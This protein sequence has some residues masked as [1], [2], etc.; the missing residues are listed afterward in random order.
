MSRAGSGMGVRGGALVVACV[1]ACLWLCGRVGGVRLRVCRVCKQSY[2]AGSNGPRS[3]RF[4]R[5]RWVGAEVSKHLGSRSGD[6]RAG[7]GLA[8][9]WDCCEEES[10]D[11]PGC[12]VGFHRSYD[13]EDDDERAYLLN[14]ALGGGADVEP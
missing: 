1:C 5:G 9:F 11:G 2:E 4:H 7:T 6:Q 13:V 3:C 10:L 14:K 8:V 12:M